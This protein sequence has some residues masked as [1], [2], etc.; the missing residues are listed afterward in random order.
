MPACFDFL[1]HAEDE[2][3]LAP[4]HVIRVDPQTGQVATVLYTDGEELSGSSVGAPYGYQFVVGAV[5]DSEVL[6]CPR[7]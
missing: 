7:N 3:A 2:A 5:F 6:I 4:S 1:A